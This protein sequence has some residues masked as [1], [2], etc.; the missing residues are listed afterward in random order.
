M[1]FETGPGNA[2]LMDLFAHA[3]ARP[4]A[5]SVSYEV[6]KLLPNDTDFSV[7]RKL[8][9]SGFNFGFIE[10]GLALSLGP[11]QS[12]IHRP[13]IAAAHRRACV[14]SHRRACR[15]RSRNAECVVRCQ[16]L[17]CLRPRHRGLAGRDQC[18]DRAGCAAGPRR[19]DCRASRRLHV[20][21]DG[22]GRGCLRRRARAA[23]CIRMAAV[24]SA[25]HLARR[26]SARSS[27]ALARPRRARDG[28][29]TRSADRRRN[30]RLARRC[31]RTAAGELARACAARRRRRAHDR[32]RVVSVPLAG[33]RRRDRRMDRDSAP[34]RLRA[35]AARDRAGRI[36][37]RGVLLARVPARAR[38]RA[39]LRPEPVQDPGADSVLAGAGAGLRREPRRSIARRVGLV[40]AVRAWSSRA[41]RRS[42]A[43]RP[44]MRRTIRAA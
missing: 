12:S 34:E 33:I 3:V 42:R 16:F 29:N 28:R 36:R 22:L 26:A 44:R 41:R 17:R 19:A 31:A 8:G 13:S 20:A 43:R 14:R 30:R 27:A 38:A 7:Y 18:A 5:S 21:C 24:V 4:S 37:S 15:R 39:R 23:V 9:L 1:M 6:Y 40:R 10:F 35:L 25:G 2:R 32:R 11:G